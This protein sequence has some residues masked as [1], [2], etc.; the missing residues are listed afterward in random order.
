MWHEYSDLVRAFRIGSLL[1]RGAV[2]TCIF[3]PRLNAFLSNVAHKDLYVLDAAISQA[4]LAGMAPVEQLLVVAYNQFLKL[5]LRCV[6][7]V[8]CAAMMVPTSILHFTR[9]I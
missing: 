7:A 1:D 3:D 5:L 2:Q 6:E 9:R 8:P 4:G